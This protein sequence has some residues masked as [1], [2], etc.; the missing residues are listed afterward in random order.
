MCGFSMFFGIYES[1]VRVSKAEL[2][3]RN[4]CR[5]RNM[6][7]M[8]SLVCWF[9]W[10]YTFQAS[11]MI[12]S[13]HLRTPGELSAAVHEVDTIPRGSSHVEDVL[14]PAPVDRELQWD[15]ICDMCAAKRRVEKKEK[16]VGSSSVDI[17][18][19][20]TLICM[21][22]N[23]FFV[24]AC[25]CLLGVASCIHF[26]SSAGLGSFQF[27]WSHWITVFPVQF[28]LKF[29]QIDLAME[30]SW[31]MLEKYG[32]LGFQQ[33]PAPIWGRQRGPHWALPRLHCRHLSGAEKCGLCT[34]G[35]LRKRPGDA[36]ETGGIQHIMSTLDS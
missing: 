7:I 21:V 14:G 29:V 30:N 18:S 6:Q 24:K 4:R 12:Q 19:C 9:S 25:W 27:L 2:F 20:N 16:H 35:K 28:G 31:E 5:N 23:V 36:G 8:A 10:F 13:S 15:M 22:P 26:F 34:A 17:V 11:S 32:I 3:S 1:S 33:M